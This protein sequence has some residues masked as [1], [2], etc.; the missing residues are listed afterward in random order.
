MFT[1]LEML[2]R[3]DVGMV[4][5][6]AEIWGI[7]LKQ[8]NGDEALKV[9]ASAM[10]D[11]QRAETVWDL[12]DDGQRGALQSILAN[13][14]LQMNKN[15]FERMYGEIQ[16]MGKAEITKKKPHRN[17]TTIAQGL[18]YRG[19]I[20]DGF[21]ESKKTIVPIIY[22]PQD[23]AAILPVHKTAYANL[24]Y[25]SDDDSYLDLEDEEQEPDEDGLEFTIEAI[26]DNK[27]RNTQTADTSII[28]DMVTLLAYLRLHGA[29]VAE[30]TFLPSEIERILPF[31]IK[32]DPKRLTFMLDVG[33]SANLIEVQQGRAYPRRD[34]LQK[35]LT[36]PRWSQLKMLA[37]AWKDG[38]VY[39]DMWHIDGLYPDLNAFNYNSRIAREAI[40]EMLQT[41]APMKDW[42]S[43]QQFIDLVK[44]TDAD[45]QRPN[46]DYNTWYIRNEQGEYLNGFESWDAV[47]GA[48]IEFML[49]YPLFW[50][51]MLDNANNEQVV[52]L[53]AYGRGYVGMEKFPQPT[54][55]TDKVLMKDDGTLFASRKVPRTDRFT[56][57][58]FTSWVS[59]A[60][61]YTYRIEKS[62][63][64]RAT[65]QGISVQQIEAFLKKQLD[66][67]PIPAG[68][69]RL[70]SFTES[71]PVANVSF[72]YV[73][74]IRTTSKD[75]LDKMY[76]EPATRRFLG[77]RL[78][79]MA[80]VI[81]K[82]KY[83]NL[84]AMLEQNGI[85][86]DL[87]E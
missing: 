9:L 53:N 62:S 5:A 8:Y 29:G 6:L 39:Q 66:N 42:W 67:R 75:V 73:L 58:R 61:L 63:L 18:Y 43:I 12:L 56:L 26:D 65:E 27:I 44:E 48:L 10:L 76:D 71:A 80:A 23:L 7:S 3:T 14:Q 74:V 32:Q 28:D 78:G 79:D 36:A 60:E 34:G 57:A 17:P 86:V 72:E 24:Q 38:T 77:A 55:P 22:V 49:L 59:G 30:D 37:D 41:A 35:W 81:L 50:L 21:D 2:K 11:P 83:E 25:E 51:G 19:L 84:K 45:F 46:S 64:Q 40:L 20:G 31:M 69:M 16:K 13:K 33:V 82:D 54:D 70:L 15:L 47:D 87:I 52:R 85:H 1:L 68:I 4:D